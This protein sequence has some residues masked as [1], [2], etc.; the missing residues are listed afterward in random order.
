MLKKSDRSKAFERISKSMNRKKRRK[1]VP[2]VTRSINFISIVFA[3]DL[4]KGNL[5]SSIAEEKRTE[6]FHLALKVLALV[7]H[8]TCFIASQL[9]KF[10]KF[11]RMGRARVY[12][13][14]SHSATFHSS[15]R[16]PFALFQV[17]LSYEWSLRE[18]EEVKI[19]G[20][21]F[22]GM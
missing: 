4:K 22:K 15:S 7:F 9:S 17:K 16:E 11:I 3:R 12:V 8:A 2:K 19:V 5:F 1:L 18:Q 6:S 21:L 14:L 20:G 13:S 10:A